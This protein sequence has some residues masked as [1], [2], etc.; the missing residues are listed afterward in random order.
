LKTKDRGGRCD[1]WHLD[2]TTISPIRRGDCRIRLIDTVRGLQHID[3][4]RQEFAPQLP[5]A[6]VGVMREWPLDEGSLAG[7]IDEK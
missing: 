7:N 2:Q 3:H 5:G 1:R 6:Q 4:R